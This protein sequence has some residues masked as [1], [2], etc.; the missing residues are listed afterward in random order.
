M[1]HASYR[2]AAARYFGVCALCLTGVVM[3]DG[4]TVSAAQAR[5]GASHLESAHWVRRTFEFTYLGFTTQYSCSG[6]RDKLASVLVQLGARRQD[7]NVH[8]VGC[9]NTLGK[10]EPAPSVE[11]SFYVL[12][13]VSG[14]KA[15]SG[16]RTVPAQWRTVDVHLARSGV[17][18]AG[19]CDLMEQ[20][21]QKLLPM[22]AARDVRFSSN[23]IP[24]QLTLPGALLQARVLRAAPNRHR[25]MRAH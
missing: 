6:L 23:C 4:G 13:P 24:N 22:F 25:V 18:Q 7:L 3:F 2:Q 5:V 11:G 12:Q 8:P 20:I 1:S 17:D 19:Q 21:K 10:P 14:R 15:A 9:A 16:V